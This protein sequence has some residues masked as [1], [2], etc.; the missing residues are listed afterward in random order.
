LKLYRFYEPRGLKLVKGLG[1]YV[2]DSTGRRYLDT[3]NGNGVGFLGHGNKYVIS[4]IREQLENIY[5]ASSSYDLEV[6][7]EALELLSKIVPPRYDNVSFL[8]SGAEA[9][10]LAIKMARIYTGRKKII[11]F[12]GSFHGRTLGALSVTGNKRYWVGIEGL[13]LG[14]IPV[15]FTK[16]GE[17]YSVDGSDVAAIILETIQGEGGVNPAPKELIESVKA[18]SDKWGSLIIVDEIQTGFGRTGVHWSFIDVGLE[19]HI[20][21]AGKAMAGG[22]PISAVFFSSE[23][24]SKMP[25]AIHGSTFGG[26]PLALAAL[27]GGLRAYIYERVWER[28]G[29]TGYLLINRLREAIG[30]SRLVKEVRGRGL[31]VGV[32]LRVNPLNVVKCLQE[33]GVLATRAGTTVVRFLPPYMITRE[34]IETIAGA[35]ASCIGGL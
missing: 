31:M 17:I 16:P 23:I 6:A 28:A 1:Q 4:S 29:A 18:F 34:D 32:D 19:P 11:Y 27:R 24:G 30:S 14:T 26:N 12:T 7:E 8:N 20:F 22:F 3:H 35:M 10:E 33:R 13:D 9:V 5:I 21:T 2:W 15:E 25:P